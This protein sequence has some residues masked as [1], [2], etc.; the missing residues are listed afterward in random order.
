MTT[1]LTPQQRAG[2]RSAAVDA[3]VAAGRELGLTITD[4]AVLHDVFSVVVHLAPSP[5]ANI[6][7]LVPQLPEL[8]EYLAPAVEHWQTTPFAGGED[9]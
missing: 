2:R 9:D 5:P 7:T 4:A 8:T 1:F 3:A 6:L